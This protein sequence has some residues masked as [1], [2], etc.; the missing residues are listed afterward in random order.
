MREDWAYNGGVNVVREASLVVV[1]QYFHG[2]N[3]AILVW[4]MC[5][6]EMVVSRLPPR[7]FQGFFEEGC[8]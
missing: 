1:I 4:T 3:V 8:G 7:Y 5:V 6:K 2:Q